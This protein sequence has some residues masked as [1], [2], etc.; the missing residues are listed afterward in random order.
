MRF[1]CLKLERGWDGQKVPG[2]FSPD[3]YGRF[4]NIDRRKAAGTRE[5]RDNLR[6][7]LRDYF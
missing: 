4:P 5:T 6:K 3:I 1:R 7:E 2:V